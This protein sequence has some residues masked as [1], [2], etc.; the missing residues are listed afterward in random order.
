MLA[1]AELTPSACFM[2]Y[3]VSFAVLIALPEGESF[4][5]EVTGGDTCTVLVYT[6]LWK[7]S[8]KKMGEMLL[9]IYTLQKLQKCIDHTCCRLLWGY[10]ERKQSQRHKETDSLQRGKGNKRRALL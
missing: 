3:F 6:V 9:V 4:S 2:L 7:C 5:K 10:R 8:F 1:A